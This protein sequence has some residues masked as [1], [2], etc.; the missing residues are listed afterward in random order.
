MKRVVATLMLSLLVVATA[1]AAPPAQQPVPYVSNEEA[2]ARLV[3][4]CRTG[5]QACDEYTHLL[6]YCHGMRGIAITAASMRD[7]IGRYDDVVYI[8][9]SGQRR[10]GRFSQ[11]YVEPEHVKQIVSMAFESGQ[12]ADELSARIF[13]GCL[14]AWDDR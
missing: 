10:G 14:L 13:H 1:Q 4:A 11:F 3:R 6:S 12:S 5:P 2:S 9:S 7:K 8:A